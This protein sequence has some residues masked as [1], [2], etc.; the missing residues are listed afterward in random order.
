[1]TTVILQWSLDGIAQ[2]HQLVTCFGEQQNYDLLEII[3]PLS[4]TPPHV[5]ISR[6]FN[7]N[8]ERQTTMW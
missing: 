6:I 8:P 3:L 1:M 7:E 2:Q 5:P 4:P